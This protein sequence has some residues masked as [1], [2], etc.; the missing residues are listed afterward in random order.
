[1]E[2]IDS[3]PGIMPYRLILFGTIIECQEPDEAIALA[4]LMESSQHST[5][6][7]ESATHN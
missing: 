1:M 4:R 7:K 2:K 5:L 3:E 6:P